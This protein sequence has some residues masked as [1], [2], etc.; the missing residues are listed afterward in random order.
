[1]FYPGL[2]W[3]FFSQPPQSQHGILLLPDVQSCFK[4]LLNKFVLCTG[5]LR[6]A[7]SRV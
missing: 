4:I 2:S 1:M 7:E 5:H 3:D 6:L